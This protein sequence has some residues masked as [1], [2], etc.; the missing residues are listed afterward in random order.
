MVHIR[1]RLCVGGEGVGREWSHYGSDNVQ[2]IR[3]RFNVLSFNCKKE[4]ESE[5]MVIKPYKF[6]S[7]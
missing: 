4:T 7:R 1:P 2:K 6:H 3:K 5:G